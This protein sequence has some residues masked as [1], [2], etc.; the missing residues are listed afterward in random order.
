[1]DSTEKAKVTYEISQIDELV[2]KAQVLVSLC[3]SKEPDFIEITAVGGVLHSFYNGLENIFVLFGKSLGF[4]FDAS[5]RWHR[6]LI[7]FMFARFDFLP[8]DLRARLTEHMGFR[9]FFRHSYGYTIKWEK[10]SY[11]FMGMTGFWQTMWREIIRM[12]DSC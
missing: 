1:M 11:L 8:S 3:E 10:C 9:H 12:C 5:P 4:D 7:D 6:N 2:G